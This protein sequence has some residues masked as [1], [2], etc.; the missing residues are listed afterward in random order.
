LAFSWH[1]DSDGHFALWVIDLQQP[2]TRP[3]QLLSLVLDGQ[4][5]GFL[6]WMSPTDW[7]P[8]GT[9]IAVYI[10]REDGPKRETQRIDLVNAKDG[11]FRTLRS[12]EAVGQVSNVLFSPD[13]KFLAYGIPGAKPA[14][15]RD[16]AVTPLAGGPE[17]PVIVDPA[18][19]V[20][21]GWSPDGN[22]LLFTSDRSGT[23]SLYAIA[24]V[25][26]KRQGEPVLIKQDFSSDPLRLNA[27]GE[28]YYENRDVRRLRGDIKI[29]SFDFAT[30]RFFEPPSIG[31]KEFI[32][33]NAAAD[34]SRDGKYLLNISDRDRQILV[35]HSAETGEFVRELRPPLTL[36]QGVPWPKWAPDSKSIAVP[37]TDANGRQ[38]I[39]R[40]DAQTGEASPLALSERGENVRGPAFSPD[41]KKFFYLRILA[42]A[43]PVQQRLRVLIER[44][45]ASGSEKEIMRGNLFV[46]LLSPDGKY[47]TTVRTDADGSAVLLVPI[48]G[49]QPI[50]LM[51]VKS[52]ETLWVETWAPDSRSVFIGKLPE[53][54]ETYFRVSIDGTGSHPVH[55]DQNMG[56]GVSLHPDGRRIAY[57]VE[58]E[59]TK[60]EI[61]VLQNFFSALKQTR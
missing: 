13:G 4:A 46:M 32:G 37:A 5:G 12:E 14:I 53:P 29:A 41:G 40:V 19:D 61:W 1:Y 43:Q 52:P 44:D 51:R 36:N 9:Q 10:Q 24:F 25:N 16:I 38:G 26:G 54:I 30:E 28:L 33:H 56:L 31:V 39:F 42:G 48:N 17:I 27:S 60:T 58:S 50:E 45:L 34:W 49:G 35:I 18:Q 22:H 57:S 23:K 21:V 11:S 6:N 8:D 3:R 7:S 59:Q 55:L 2:T 20:L 15:Q 47:F